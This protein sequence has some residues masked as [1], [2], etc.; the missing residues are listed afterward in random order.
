MR[1][2]QGRSLHPAG[3]H[4][5]RQA[6]REREIVRQVLFARC[7]AVPTDGTHGPQGH[8]TEPVLADKVDRG[9]YANAVLLDL[10]DLVAEACARVVAAEPGSD[11]IRTM[12]E[13]FQYW[14]NTE[15]LAREPAAAAS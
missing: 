6:P 7:F 5:R 12:L 11:E 15:V 3:R 10:A 8:E 1:L 14:S 9:S 2:E 4:R 13:T